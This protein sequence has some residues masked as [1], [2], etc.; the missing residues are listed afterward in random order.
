MF[1]NPPGSSNPRAIPTYV[2]HRNILRMRNRRRNRRSFSS[3]STP[4][5]LYWAAP[6]SSH[7]CSPPPRSTPHQPSW[8]SVR[9]SIFET[10]VTLAWQSRDRKLSTR[11]SLPLIPDHPGTL[12]G[13]DCNHGLHW[14]V[15]CQCMFDVWC[16]TCMLLAKIASCL[17]GRVVDRLDV[18]LPRSR[19]ERVGLPQ[20]R[21]RTS[22]M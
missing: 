20:C 12:H 3:R 18:Q 1:L 2:A 10:S 19:G 4:M 22:V 17:N 13:R 7:S 6:T 21:A 9:Y 15:G 11:P 8:D 14:S 16:C 5:L